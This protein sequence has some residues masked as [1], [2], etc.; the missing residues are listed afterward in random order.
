MF[1][2]GLEPLRHM[3]LKYNTYAEVEEK[4]GAI[5]EELEPYFA[6]KI[7]HGIMVGAPEFQGRP[8]FYSLLYYLLMNNIL[9]SNIDFD[10]VQRLTYGVATTTP[11]TL[12][13]MMNVKEFQKTL[14]FNP[15][16]IPKFLYQQVLID[17]KQEKQNKEKWDIENA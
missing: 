3:L 10:T 13:N 2:L 6:T 5:I 1:L 11:H 12:Q 15:I 4:E 17:L 16:S 9:K 7:I 14:D 8:R